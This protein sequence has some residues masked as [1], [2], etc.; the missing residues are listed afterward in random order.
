MV[1]A[2]F[3]VWLTLRYEDKVEE[4]VDEFFLPKVEIISGGRIGDTP[5]SYFLEWRLVSEGLNSDGSQKSRSGRFEDLFL[6]WD[7]NEKWAVKVGQFRALNQVDVS[8]RLS[9]SEPALFSSSLPG[10][11]TSD[12]RIQGLRSFSPSGRSPSIAF[13]FQPIEGTKAAEGLFLGATLPFPGE[14]RLRRLGR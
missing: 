11:P 9:P 5:L 4:D 12:A 7:V 14:F 8:L 13:Q 1:P 6:Q 10:D 3:A 2:W